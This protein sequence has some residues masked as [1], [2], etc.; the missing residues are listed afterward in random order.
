MW[1]LLTFGEISISLLL[2]FP[3]VATL[4]VVVFSFVVIWVFVSTKWSH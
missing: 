2:L 3:I 4:L 1:A